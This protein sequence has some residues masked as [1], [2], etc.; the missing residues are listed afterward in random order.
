VRDLVI[1]VFYVL[2]ARV[3]L[4]AVKDN[5]CQVSITSIAVLLSE[6]WGARVSVHWLGGQSS[7]IPILRT[8]AVPFSSSVITANLTFQHPRI[9]YQDLDVSM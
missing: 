8:D 5:L 3:N 6:K 2:V 4:N 7:V 1:S 9:V